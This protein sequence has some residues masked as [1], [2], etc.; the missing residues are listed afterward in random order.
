MRQHYWEMLLSA[1]ISFYRGIGDLHHRKYSVVIII[2]TILALIR[3][4][5]DY[6]HYIIA[7]VTNH[8]CVVS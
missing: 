3:K 7:I 6:T 4:L 2:S 1:F 5:A 8:V